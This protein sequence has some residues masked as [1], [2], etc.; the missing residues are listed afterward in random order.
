[1]KQV[2]IID[3]KY[4]GQIFEGHS[5]YYDHLHTGNSPDLFTVKHR[6]EKLPLPLTK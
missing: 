3:G 5:F 4:A 1:M 6:M 2:K